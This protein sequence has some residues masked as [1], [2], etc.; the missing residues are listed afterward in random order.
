MDC[1]LK[2]DLINGGCYAI[3]DLMYMFYSILLFI[4]NNKHILGIVNQC[5]CFI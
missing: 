5:K 2:L 3:L 4:L 1:S